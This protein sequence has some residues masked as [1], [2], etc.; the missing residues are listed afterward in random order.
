V[1]GP[2]GGDIG[3]VAAAFRAAGINADTIR[4]FNERIAATMDLRPLLARITA[5]TL[6]ITGASDPFGG[7]TS[8]EIA[9]AL[10]DPTVVTLAG[11]DRF[12]FL[13]AA[14]RAAWSR[15]VLDFLAG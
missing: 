14:H 1:L 2:R 6:V 9:A 5:P 12:P 7:P 3:P 11:A 13:E 15:A 4:H 8:D 10:P